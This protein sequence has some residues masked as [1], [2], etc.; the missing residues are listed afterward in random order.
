[1]SLMRYFDSHLLLHS[2]FRALQTS[3]VELLS[4]V[5]ATLDTASDADNTESPQIFFEQ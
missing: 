4:Q 3:R 5:S 1:M 2:T